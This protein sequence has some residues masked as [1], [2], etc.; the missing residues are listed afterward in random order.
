MGYGVGR[1][2]GKVGEINKEGG[3]ENKGEWKKRVSGKKG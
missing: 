3:M 2:N 1:W